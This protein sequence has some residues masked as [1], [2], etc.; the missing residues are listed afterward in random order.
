MRHEAG[1]DGVERALAA[2]DDV[3]VAGLERKSRTPILQADACARNDNARAK[4][5][6][7]GLYQRHH[8]AALV[9]GCKIHGPAGRR[10]AVT[11]VLRT[12]RID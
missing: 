6:V 10:R 9:G 12:H 1:N 7:I 4:A 11:V 3:R 8:H 2:A 5:H